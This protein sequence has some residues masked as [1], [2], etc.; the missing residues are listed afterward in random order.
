MRAKLGRLL[1]AG[2]AS[3]GSKTTRL[4]HVRVDLLG[5]YDWEARVVHEEQKKECFLADGEGL[6]LRRMCDV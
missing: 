1:T 6:M 5:A 3:S 2:N 4:G